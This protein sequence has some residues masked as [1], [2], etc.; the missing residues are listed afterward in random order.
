M[1]SSARCARTIDR[2]AER[3]I[4]L[5]ESIRRNPELGF[6]EFKTARLVEE[7]LKESRS[8]AADRARR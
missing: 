8:L 4:G 2:K 3:I 7:T 1:T 6:K 5:G